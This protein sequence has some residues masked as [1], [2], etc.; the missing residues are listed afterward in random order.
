MGS[1]DP[2]RL[3]PARDNGMARARGDGIFRAGAGAGWASPAGRAAGGPG[4]PSTPGPDLTAP[5]V[6]HPMGAAPQQAEGGVLGLITAVDL[7]A[8]GAGERTVPA[9]ALTARPVLFAS[10]PMGP[11]TR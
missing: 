5:S 9:A 11:E 1:G 10:G 6:L 7:G 4:L 8:A 2:S 3:S